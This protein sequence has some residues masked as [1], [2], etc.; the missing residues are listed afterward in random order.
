MFSSRSYVANSS[1][2]SLSVGFKGKTSKAG[3]ESLLGGPH[4]WTSI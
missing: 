4:K 2:A 1:G 3:Q